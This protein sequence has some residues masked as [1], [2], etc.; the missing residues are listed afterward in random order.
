[1]SQLLKPCTLYPNLVMSGFV[2]FFLFIS[3]EFLRNH[4]KSH[5]NHKKGKSNFVG[6]HMSRSF[7]SEL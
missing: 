7:L 5:K 6:L 3:I 4:S 1:M 2:F